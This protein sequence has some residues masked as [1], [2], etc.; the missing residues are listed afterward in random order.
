MNKINIA[1]EKYTAPSVEGMK[2]TNLQSLLV[3]LSMKGEIEDFEEG[4]EL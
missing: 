4:D 1:R 3:S 2:L